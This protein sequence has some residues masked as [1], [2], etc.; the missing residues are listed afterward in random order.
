MLQAISQ[1]LEIS[2]NPTF[3]T[4]LNADNEDR[5]LTEKLEGLRNWASENPDFV[6]QFDNAK[7]RTGND[8]ESRRRR[9]KMVC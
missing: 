6:N 7:T 9:L 1:D 5:I 4:R 2:D 8:I 3:Y